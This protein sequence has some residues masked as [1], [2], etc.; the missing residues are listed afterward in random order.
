MIFQ[1]PVLKQDITTRERKSM[2][3]LILGMAIK[4]YNYMPYYESPQKAT[5]TNCGSIFADLHELNISVGDDT[6]RKYFRIR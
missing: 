5:G 4:G 1:K 2:L 6:I 3:K